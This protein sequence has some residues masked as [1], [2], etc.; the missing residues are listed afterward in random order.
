MSAA[1]I[2][3]QTRPMSGEKYRSP[4]RVFCAPMPCLCRPYR[5]AF[6]FSASPLPVSLPPCGEGLIF[7]LGFTPA[8]YNRAQLPHTASTGRGTRF[9]GVP[10]L[11]WPQNRK[12]GHTGASFGFSVFSWCASFAAALPAGA[13]GGN[14]QPLGWGEL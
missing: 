5:P 11:P 9:A 3:L 7:S 12:Q 4:S 1:H 8:H 13:P 10:S 6:S 2:S 14:S